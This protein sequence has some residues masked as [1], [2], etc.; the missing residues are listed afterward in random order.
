MRYLKNVKRTDLKIHEKIVG[1]GFEDPVNYEEMKADINE[2]KINVSL[3]I[4]PENYIVCGYTRFKIANELGIEE[5]P[6]E[7][8][9][10]ESEDEMIDFAIKDNLLRRHM[11]K[12]Q[13]GLFAAMFLAF[14]TSFSR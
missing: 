1:L 5:L 2:N 7:V 9:E 4:T 13:R 3:V 8:R 12:F 10:F 11:N 6:C 14:P